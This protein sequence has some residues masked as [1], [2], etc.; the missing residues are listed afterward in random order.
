MTADPPALRDGSRRKAA[1][2]AIGV[3]LV[4]LVA[5]GWAYYQNSRLPKRF[6]VVEPGRLYRSGEVTPG[7]LERVVEQFGVRTVLSL[8][9][10]DAPE[11]R[12]E[13]AAAERLGLRWLNVPLRGDGSSRPEDRE[14]IRRILFDDSLGPLL[15]HCAAGSNRTGMACGLYRI[16]RQGW[17]YERTL[18]E[19]RQYGFDDLDKHENVRDALREAAAASTKPAP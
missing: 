17:S 8:L 9:D 3:A 14:Q 6:G 13:R 2:W 12:A 15:V 1:R 5:G 4:I 7:Q 18:E 10:P 16:E 11:S 19:L